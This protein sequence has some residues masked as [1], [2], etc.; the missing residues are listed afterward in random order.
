MIKYD[1][2]SIVNRT[3]LLQRPNLLLGYRKDTPTQTEA[4]ESTLSKVPQKPQLLKPQASPQPST[5]ASTAKTEK[6]DLPSA[7]SNLKVTT[8]K[9]P[10]K[11]IE[12]V[13]KQKIPWFAGCEYQ[14]QMEN[15][16]EMF[17]YNQDLRSHIK[18]HHGD[19]D[20]YLDK[21]EK[22]ETKEDYLTCR[23]CF[24]NLKRHFSSFY[25]HLRDAHSSMTLE[26]YGKKH[27]MKDYEK[28][29]KVKQ[30]IKDEPVENRPSTPSS[31]KRTRNPS[32][33]SDKS[34]PAKKAKNSDSGVK[35]L[36]PKIADGNCAPKIMDKEVMVKIH[37][38][39]IVKTEP[40]SE[41]KVLR[42]ES[43]TA[44]KLG[45][46]GSNVQNG[47]NGKVDKPWHAGCE[48][49]CQICHALH[50][51]LNELLFHVRTVH[52]I[53]GNISLDSQLEIS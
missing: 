9:K 35:S 41:P 27:K 10:G 34:G 5:R 32:L 33:E 6:Q 16:G 43:K 21:F 44:N 26:E 46:E 48:Y 39:D 24:M 52:N 12:V 31:K 37:T 28:S 36:V 15:C 47:D 45:K 53:T 20:D 2:D 42:S 17:F 23:E 19:P 7:P 3:L 25:L 30:F 29:F 50:Y 49:T 1:I 18:K 38:K 8:G 13:H 14:C 40:K 51:G 22:F 4:Q 11:V